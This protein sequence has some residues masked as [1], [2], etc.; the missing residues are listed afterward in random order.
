LIGCGGEGPSGASTVPEW[1]LSET[2]RI[3]SV[4]GEDALSSV[5]D[6]HFD[7]SHV[8]VLDSRPYRVLLFSADGALGGSFGRVGQGPAELTAP[9]SIGAT[10]DTLWVADPY[11]HGIQLFD[12]NGEFI[13][14]VGFQL[15]PDRMGAEAY[16]I[17]LLASHRAV[18]G[19]V[20]IPMARVNAGQ[21][22][23]HNLYLTD[24]E[25]AVLDTLYRARI[26]STD[27][28][29]AELAEGQ[30]AQGG[31][32]LMELP[33]HDVLPDG[34]GVVVTERWLPSEDDAFYSVKVWNEEAE[35]VGDHVIPYEPLPAAGWMERAFEEFRAVTGTLPPP[36]VRE[37]LA[38][39]RTLPPV[40]DLLAGRDGIILTRREETA[41]DSVRWDIFSREEGGR[42]AWIRVPRDLDILAASKNVAWAVMKDDL[43]V[44]FLIR[45]TFQAR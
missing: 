8:W 13:R 2:L 20:G 5:V 45:Y 38:E 24:E 15:P 37:A 36:E 12:A 11:G 31:H 34:S 7:D 17:G 23:H 28:F 40:S 41:A 42:I 19:P 4:D 16:P 44:P 10:G 33:L 30:M 14:S 22:D 43:G 6:V 3:G 32:P 29:E 25:G 27:F 9:I 1:A 39:R 26:P 18:A 21:V 35:L